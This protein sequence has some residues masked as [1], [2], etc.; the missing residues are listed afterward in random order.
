M[1]LFSLIRSKID[2]IR[3]E[4]R[5]TKRRNRRSTF[6]SDAVYVDG[7]YIFSSSRNSADSTESSEINSTEDRE[8]ERARKDSGKWSRRSIVE[9]M[10]WRRGKDEAAG[11]GSGGG[12]RRGKNRLSRVS[13]R[14]VPLWADRG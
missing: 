10:D 11:N 4:N 5:Y 9:K 13:V 14:E 1:H 8:S 7:E 6:V 12:S 2:I 3:I